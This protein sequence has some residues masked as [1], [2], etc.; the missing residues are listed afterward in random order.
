MCGF[1]SKNDTVKQ[2]LIVKLTDQMVELALFL[3]LT[4]MNVVLIV[5]V[6]NLPHI[7]CSNI[8]SLRQ[9][10]R[11]SRI[12]CMRVVHGP[13]LRGG[14]KKLKQLKPCFTFYS[15]FIHIFFTFFCQFALKTP[16]LRPLEKSWLLTGF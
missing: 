2:Q 3:L 12:S 14:A 1:Q 8:T 11:Y 13:Q 5:K 6:S 4:F 7:F 9:K 10:I 15:H 16:N